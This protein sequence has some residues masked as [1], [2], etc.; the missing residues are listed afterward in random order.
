V[1]VD[2]ATLVDHSAGHIGS[3]EAAVL[4]QLLNDSLGSEAVRFYP[5]VGYAT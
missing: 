5:G 1:T 4:V 3:R 2:G